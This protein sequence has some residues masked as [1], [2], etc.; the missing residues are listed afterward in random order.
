MTS[1]SNSRN[2]YIHIRP[3]GVR[4]TKAVYLPILTKSTFY[5]TTA[6]SAPWAFMK[7]GFSPNYGAGRH[8]HHRGEGPMYSAKG[9]VTRQWRILMTININGDIDLS[10]RRQYMDKMK[11]HEDV[12]MEA[13]APG[14]W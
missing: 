6:S 7:W 12:I 14:N 13:N 4:E 2:S 11:L 8:L 10:T 3:I 1:T 5:V 9:M